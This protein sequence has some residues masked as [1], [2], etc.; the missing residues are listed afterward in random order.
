MSIHWYQWELYSYSRFINYC[1]LWVIGP[2]FEFYVHKGISGKCLK[3]RD[4][5]QHPLA[6]PYTNT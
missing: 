5:L 1:R 3:T 6:S 4:L 2:N